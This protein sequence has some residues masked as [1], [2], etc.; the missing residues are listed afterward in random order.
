M[1]WLDGARTHAEV[2]SSQGLNSCI[3]VLHSLIRQVLNVAA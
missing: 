1:P 3:E 2:L